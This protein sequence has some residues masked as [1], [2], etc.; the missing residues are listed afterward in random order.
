MNQ[1]SKTSSFEKMFEKVV[2]K[3]EK[4]GAADTERIAQFVDSYNTLK[5]MLK[6]SGC[7]ITHEVHKDCVGMGAI[8]IT[9][10]QLVIEDTHVFREVSELA[11][12]FEVYPKTDGT[13][14]MNFAFYGL[15]KKGV[16]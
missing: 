11:N 7:K 3:T 10:E 12:N 4:Y 5:D 8:L 1:K 9:S 13:I 14:Q 2:C 6:K 15:I 16:K